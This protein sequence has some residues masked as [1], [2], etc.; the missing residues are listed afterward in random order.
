LGGVIMITILPERGGGV[1]PIGKIVRV[2]R[3][4]PEP[5]PIAAV[6]GSKA[7]V[8]SRVVAGNKADVEDKIQSRKVRTSNGGNPI[9][10][11]RRFFQDTRQFSR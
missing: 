11:C 10:G 1:E 5:V 2:L 4:A 6:A 9:I 3:V 7:A 8:G